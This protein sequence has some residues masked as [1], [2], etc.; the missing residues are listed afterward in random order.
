MHEMPFV[1]GKIAATCKD[2]APWYSDAL[3]GFIHC[4]KLW[5]LQFVM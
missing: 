1:S 3:N 4:S 2:A 5:F